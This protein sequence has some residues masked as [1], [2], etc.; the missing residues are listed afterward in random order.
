MNIKIQNPS[1]FALGGKTLQSGSK[2]IA[3][4]KWD[5][6]NF[7]ARQQ[8]QAYGKSYTEKPQRQQGEGSEVPK[9]K[10]RSK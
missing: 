5:R 6:I 9:A 1:C 7:P 10:P 3:L 4:G 2:I 8:P